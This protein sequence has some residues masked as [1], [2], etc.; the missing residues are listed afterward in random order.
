MFHHQFLLL[1]SALNVED[2]D[3]RS[4]VD[5][6]VAE[7]LEKD[8]ANRVIGAVVVDLVENVNWIEVRVREL[9]DQIFRKMFYFVWKMFDLLA[10]CEPV[11]SVLVE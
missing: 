5:V 2:Y 3:E 4:I 8:S 6:N 1:C 9:V 7:D 10:E 11:M